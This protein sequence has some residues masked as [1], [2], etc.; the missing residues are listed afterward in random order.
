MPDISVY[1]PHRNH[2]QNKTLVNYTLINI[3][4]SYIIDKF[5]EKTFYVLL[6]I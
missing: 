2:I 4:F 5:Y 1:I 3:D 6:I